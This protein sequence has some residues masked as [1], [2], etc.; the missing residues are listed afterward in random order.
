MAA[1]ICASGVWTACPS[2]A[3]TK[4]LIAERHE[5]L[6]S[7]LRN[8]A[9]GQWAVWTHRLHRSIGDALRDPAEPGFARDLSRAYYARQVGHGDD[10]QRAVPDVGLPAERVA[11]QPGVAVHPA[12]AGGHRR[13]ADRSPVGDG[14][15]VGRWSSG[16]C[17]AS[18]RSR[19][20]CACT[21]AAATRKW[22]SSWVYWSM[23]AGGRC[24]KAPVPLYRTLPATRLFFGGDK[25]ELHAR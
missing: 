8:L 21:A 10:E 12:L 24:H 6:C 9:G 3:P 19:W 4:Q 17:A 5:A 15:E 25:L 16:C 22:P 2:N 14:R 13:S 1:T 20:A 18:G 11:R 7:L 23:A